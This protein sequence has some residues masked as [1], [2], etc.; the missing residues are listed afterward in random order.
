MQVDRPEAVSQGHYLA[1][2]IVPGLQQGVLRCSRLFRRK[3]ERR[4]VAA[5]VV[6]VIL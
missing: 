1:R 3:S 2:G 5:A 4:P 6:R